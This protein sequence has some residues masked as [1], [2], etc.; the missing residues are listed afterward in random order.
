M[1][2]RKDELFNIDQELQKPQGKLFL[3]SSVKDLFD[4]IINIEKTITLFETNNTKFEQEKDKISFRAIF[5]LV[6]TF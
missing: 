2:S 3:H 5:Q 4:S 1:L 6:H